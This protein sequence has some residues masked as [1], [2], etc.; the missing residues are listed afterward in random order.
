[1]VSVNY[2]YI[3]AQTFIIS[4]FPDVATGS[5]LSVTMQVTHPASDKFKFYVS[6]D[7]QDQIANPI[8][9]K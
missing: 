5:V 9:Y 1:M 2:Q 7:I 8:M 4:G 6:I 3:D